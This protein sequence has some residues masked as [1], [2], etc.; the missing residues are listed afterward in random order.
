VSHYSHLVVL[1]TFSKAYG[2]AGARC[3][4]LIASPE[5]VSL[6]RKIIP[7]YALTQFTIETVLR[8]LEP[9]ALA[10]MRARV[11]ALCVQRAWL[12]AALRSAAGVVHVW[13]SEANFVLVEFED[14]AAAFGKARAAGLLVR[15]VRTQ[16]GLERALRITIGTP[17]QNR[18][19]IEALR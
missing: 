3:G 9:R 7:P 19:L 16:P 1:R 5:I 15:D 17:E 11:A 8:Q 4:S 6:L 13:P 14:A 2:L 12:S 18:R 10:L